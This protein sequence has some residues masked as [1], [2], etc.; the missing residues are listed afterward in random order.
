MKLI[1]ELNETVNYIFEEDE[2]SGKKNYFIE[3]VFMQ[4][5][6]KNRNGRMYPGQVLAK[7]ANRYR[8]GENKEP[9]S[10]SESFTKTLSDDLIWGRHSTE[11]ALMGGRAIHRIWCTSELRSSPK[12]FQLLK[13]SKSSGVLV[14]EVSLDNGVL[15]S[16]SLS[17]SGFWAIC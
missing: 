5:D 1:T 16:F 11:A 13:D 17:F 7:E 12:F 8:R 14:E 9:L 3:G 15:S 2:K 6:I 4:G 10:Y